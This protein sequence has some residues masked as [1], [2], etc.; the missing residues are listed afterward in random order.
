L[1]ERIQG[2]SLDF[3]FNTLVFVKDLNQGFSSDV[4]FWFFFRILIH[5][6]LRLGFSGPGFESLIDHTNNT[7]IQ[8]R[9]SQRKRI[10]ALFVR[11]CFYGQDR[12]NTQPV[13]GFFAIFLEGS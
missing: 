1:I 12:R 3:G 8:I 13:A 10:I 6:F 4:G 2:F 11:C 5:S 9:S 7:N